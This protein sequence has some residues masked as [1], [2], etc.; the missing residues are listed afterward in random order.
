VTVEGDRHRMM[1]T[2]SGIDRRPVLL[3][4][5]LFL[6]GVL[7]G[8]VELVTDQDETSTRASVATANWVH[9]G[10][11]LALVVMLVAG[12]RRDPRGLAAFLRRPV[13][14]EGWASLLNGLVSLPLLVWELVLVLTW[15]PARIA[16]TEDWRGRRILGIETS[17]HDRRTS[18][19]RARRVVV[20]APLAL[21]AFAAA[22][23]TLYVPVR[24]GEQVFAA[25]DPDFTRDAW[26]GPSYLGAS[27][28]HWMDLACVL[29]ACSLL[30]TLATA[31]RRR[32]LVG[33]GTQD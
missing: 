22:V 24:G 16:S 31:R 27:V 11:A 17:C 30:L 32:A 3:L 20:G 15:R 4:S 7:G 33:P 10:L 6:V 26:G 21:L 1:S 12:Y 14:A 28:T 9:V 8:L 13:S 23:V 18:S 29:Y 2:G 5:G 25:L 19:V